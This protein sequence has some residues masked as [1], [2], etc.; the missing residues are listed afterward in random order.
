MGYQSRLKFQSS[1][2]LTTE[3]L[4]VMHALDGYN[5]EV[6]ENTTDDF[7]PM[8]VLREE[9]RRYPTHPPLSPIE[10]GIALRRVFGLGPDQFARRRVGGKLCRGV[11]FAKK[12]VERAIPEPT[13]PASLACSKCGGIGE[14]Y[15]DC[16]G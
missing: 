9:Y 14:H 3:E 8:D 16:T 4:C 6:S 2:Q 11:V 7:V 15:L 1:N 13:A 5:F 12:R 10:F